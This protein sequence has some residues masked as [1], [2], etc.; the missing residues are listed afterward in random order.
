MTGTVGFEI[1]DLHTD[2]LGVRGVHLRKGSWPAVQAPCIGRHA[3]LAVTMLQAHCDSDAAWKPSTARTSA[4][5]EGSSPGPLPIGAASLRGVDERRQ[6][7]R[8]G[9]GR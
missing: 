1:I 7:G 4:A 8:V 9:L 5:T 6:S 3:A 2:I